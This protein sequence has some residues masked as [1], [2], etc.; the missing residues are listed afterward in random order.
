MSGPVN[1]WAGLYKDCL[2]PVRFGPEKTY[3]V[4]GRWLEGLDVEDWGCG[5]GW[6]R[7]HATG[8]YTGVD[9]THS[10]WCDVHADLTT[11]RS[12]T[13]GLLLRHVLEHNLHWQAVLDNAVASFTQRMCIVLFTPLSDETHIVVEDPGHIGVPDISFR[14]EDITERLADCPFTVLHMET[15]STYGEERVLLVSAPGSSPASV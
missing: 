6:F 5:L 15:D 2:E 4:A 8:R 3:E 1:A 10:P 14:L 12:T 9:G 7:R 11:Y 13:P